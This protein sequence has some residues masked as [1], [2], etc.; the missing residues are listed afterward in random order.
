MHEGAPAVVVRGVLLQ[1]GGPVFEENISTG[2]MLIIAFQ[3]LLTMTP[4]TIAV[5]L[6]L[7]S[8]LGLDASTTSMLVAANFFTSGITTLI[9]VIGLGN[10]VGS[11]YPI[12]LGSSFAPLAPMIMI[13]NT[14]GLP[15]LFGSII[16]SGVVIFLLSFFMDKIMKLFPQ[17]VVGTFV[18]LIGVSLAPSALRDL[19][20]GEGS[21]TF[22]S[23]PNLALGFAVLL[24]VLL[25]ERYGKGIWRSMSLLLGIV[26]GTIVGALLGMVDPTSVLESTP[27]Q[28]IMPFA[29]GTPEFQ[30]VPILFMIVFCIIN[31]LQCIGVYSVVD[32]ICGTT[33]D[34]QT[35]ARGIRAQA[36]GQIISG[37]FNSIPSTMFNENAGLVDL[38]RVR[39]RRV[40]IATGIML[41]IV[42]VCPPI[43]AAIVAV[44]K[45]VLG[46]ATLALFGVITSSGISILSRLDFGK[47]NNFKIVGTSIAIGVGA[48]YA[49]EVFDQL[50]EA[51]S[52]VMSNGLFMVTLSAVLLNILLNGRRAFSVDED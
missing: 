40:F 44:P 24:F 16:A 13:G 48:L 20:G 26:V 43:A 7:A 30:V 14:Y 29:F 25:I 19:A 45:C 27:F 36:L 17:V 37:G 1:R 28:P 23:L 15:T 22:A 6:L 35:K 31:T 32:E 11:R 47:N 38:T 9:Q 4:G 2:K 33:S 42:G 50:P 18:T 34:A 8:G 49:S 52:M 46:G 12:I 3:H 5:P 10:L 21:A 39:D 51:V 41:L